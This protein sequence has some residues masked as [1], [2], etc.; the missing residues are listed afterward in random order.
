MSENSIQRER[1]G[2]P[3]RANLFFEQLVGSP[4]L[5]L[6]G[7]LH[8][9]FVVITASAIELSHEGESVVDAFARLAHHA[10][11]RRPR[12][13]VTVIT[14]S[15]RTRRVPVRGHSVHKVCRP[16]TLSIKEKMRPFK[17]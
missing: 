8:G 13:R 17:R 5:A 11:V 14:R 12:A 16:S 3:E 4:C 7:Q 2:E 15:C 9:A 10:A 6:A 1:L